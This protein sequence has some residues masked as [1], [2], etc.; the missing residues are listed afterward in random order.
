MTGTQ[1]SSSNKYAWNRYLDL[2]M[3]SKASRIPEIFVPRKFGSTGIPNRPRPGISS[4]PETAGSCLESVT[5]ADQGV[6]QCP[7]RINVGYDTESQK[8]HLHVAVSELLAFSK[9]LLEQYAHI[10]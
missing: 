8:F 5:L 7:T 6:I 9:L 10:L 4:F 2:S 3:N 1:R